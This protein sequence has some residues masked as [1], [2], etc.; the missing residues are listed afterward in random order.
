V[1]RLTRGAQGLVFVK[2]ALEEEK[3]QRD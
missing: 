2:C 3:N 1:L